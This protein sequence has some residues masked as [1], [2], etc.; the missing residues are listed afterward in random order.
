M[1][2]DN[3]E[4]AALAVEQAKLHA[5]RHG[6]WSRLADDLIAAL[7]RDGM[8]QREIAAAINVSQSKVAK[9]AKTRG[10]KYSRTA[11]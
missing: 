4:A 11:Q 3:L 9:I 6:K 5:S 1:K 10:I 2:S 7:I 8:S